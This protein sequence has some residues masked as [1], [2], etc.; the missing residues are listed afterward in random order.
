MLTFV[1]PNSAPRS[2]IDRHVEAHRAALLEAG[3]AAI[4]RDHWVEGFRCELKVE[5]INRIGLQLVF[6]AQFPLA[7]IA[8]INGTIE[9]LLDLYR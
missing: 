2:Q 9:R 5:A 7:Y 4:D 8:R 3:V 6:A 1:L